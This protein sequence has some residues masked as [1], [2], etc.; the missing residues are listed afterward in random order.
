V[1]LGELKAQFKA[2]VNNN[3]VNK[4]DAMVTLFINQSI[5][6]I[7]RELRVPFMEKQI[8]YTIPA[9][10][11]KLAIPSDLLELI[12]IMVDGDADGILEYQLRKSSLTEVVRD[13]QIPGQSPRRYVRQGG[14][15]ILGPTPAAG[16]K[17]LIYYYAEFAAVSADSDTN[18]ALKVAWDAVLYGALAAA[19]SYLKD[20][21]NRAEAEATY[22][23]ITTNLQKM[24]DADELAADAVVAPALHYGND[25]W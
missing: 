9:D 2:M 24:A 8:L 12:G 17:V 3:V 1:T 20:V 13:S 11:T 6:R 5:M 23:Q 10:F 7:Q 22:T 19:Y 16:D 15:W 18:T 14:S 21:E 4:N 25:E